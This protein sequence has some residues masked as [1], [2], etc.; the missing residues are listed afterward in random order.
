VSPDVLTDP[1]EMRQA[2]HALHRQRLRRRIRQLDWIDALYKA[3]V[4]GI[5]VLTV[6]FG[7]A[8]LIGDHRVAAS[9]LADLS[10]YGPAII[11]I[12]IAFGVGFGL[13]SGSHGGPLAFEAPDVTHV[14]LSPIDRGMVVRSAAYRQVRGVLAIAVLV[15]ALGGVLISQRVPTAH[16][17]DVAEWI[18][19]GVAAA[20]C[21]ALLVWGAALLAS[22]RRITS[23][24]ATLVGVVLVVWSG[25]D[26]A[27]GTVTSP[28]S[29]IGALALLPLDERV[30]VAIGV[31]VAVA[32][33]VVGLR[34]AGGL[35]LEAA[36]RRSGLVSALRFAATIQDLRVV[37][38]LHR[39]L[40]HEHARTRPWL[41]LR[42]AKPLG[43]ACWR[44]DWYG[45][46]RWPAARV[47]RVAVLGV[48]AGLAAAGTARGTTP[49]IVVA[50]LAVY[51]VGL[52][53]V[54]GLAQEID[55]PERA[56]GIPLERGEVFIRH[57]TA[58]L[59][60]M[61]VA[62]GMGLIAAV[63]VDPS[64]AAV[65]LV[66]VLGAG[67]LTVACAGLAVFLAAPEVTAAVSV[68]HPGFGM[69]RQAVPPIL[70]LVGF[71]PVIAAREAAGSADA[72]SPLG[73][74]VGAALPAFVIA[75]GVAAFL[76]S[77]KTAAI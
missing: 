39:Q 55:H 17:E 25:A 11:G 23:G 8:A 73:A 35:S 27:A 50:A 41:R 61:I 58:P 69:A 24:V 15:G 6:L 68:F 72:G 32:V 40:A 13:R 66:T 19:A 45:I 9:T 57:L 74:A 77:R 37:I 34:V 71:L 36:E 62:G 33:V 47:T 16:G 20:L 42:P 18:V 22:G 59:G 54:E 30:A 65:G 56:F 67:V 51:V 43:R 46:L 2:L 1:A 49:L 26:A 10:D 63:A 48:V 64:Y 38:L 28:L 7:A 52:D 12:A 5:L 14:M 31:V 21:A 53:A 3:Y 4:T 70:T 75:F 76:R 29:W 44:R 60:V